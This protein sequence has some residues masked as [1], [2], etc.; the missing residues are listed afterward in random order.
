MLSGQETHAA[1]PFSLSGYACPAIT[2]LML[3]LV[4]FYKRDPGV[5]KYKCS[6]GAR[7]PRCRVSMETE[8]LDNEN[9][10]YI[11]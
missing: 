11:L 5:K 1:D 3:Y 9:N 2:V 10:P 8:L 4:E 7:G 6:M